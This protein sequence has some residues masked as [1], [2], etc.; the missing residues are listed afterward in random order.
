VIIDG[1]QYE[2]SMS[3][4]HCG[5]VNTHLD[6]VETFGREREDSETGVHVTIDVFSGKYFVDND[7]SMSPSPRRHG[8]I[9]SFWCEGCEFLTGLYIVQHKG[10]DYI[11]IGR[12]LPRVTLERQDGKIIDFK[13]ARIE[14]LRNKTGK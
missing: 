11:H 1:E 7:I 8:A 13:S 6:S 4:A 10:S 12:I 14:H 3:C 2:N 5:C 9:V